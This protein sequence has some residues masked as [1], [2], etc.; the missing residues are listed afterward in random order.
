MRKIIILHNKVQRV[1]K[2]S[3][4]TSRTHSLYSFLLCG[5][6][7]QLHSETAL[8]GVAVWLQPRQPAVHTQQFPKDWE[9]PPL[10]AAPQQMASWSPYLTRPWQGQ[11]HCPFM[12]LTVFPLGCFSVLGSFFIPPSQ[13]HIQDGA[14][15]HNL[16]WICAS[17]SSWLPNL[18]KL[19]HENCWFL[20][21][22]LWA[23]L[24]NYGPW[25][26]S[27]LLPDFISK[28]SFEHI[29]AH[30]C[31]YFIWLLSRS[32]SRTVVTETRWPCRI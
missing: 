22:H 2:S 16:A 29:R 8:P 24:T 7:P 10:P 23:G 14:V 21:K 13:S 19:C 26:K 25:A 11:W 31:T 3:V 30:L 4:T 1:K 15:V 18:F 6:P 27:S 9:G 20:L 5:L 12:Y 32:N 17:I 28:V